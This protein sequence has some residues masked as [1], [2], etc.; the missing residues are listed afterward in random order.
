MATYI[1][2]TVQ[3]Y[4]SD[5]KYGWNT[6]GTFFTTGGTVH[7]PSENN[8]WLALEFGDAFFQ[9]G[10]VVF[11]DASHII[12]FNRQFGLDNNLIER[13]EPF[14]EEEP[15]EFQERIRPTA[16]YVY[17]VDNNNNR[18]GE[19]IIFPANNIYGLDRRGSN[20]SSGGDTHWVES[21]ITDSNTRVIRE[22]FNAMFNNNAPSEQRLRFQVATSRGGAALTV[23]PQ[24]D[25]PPPSQPGI[26]STQVLKRFALRRPITKA[27]IG[28]ATTPYWQHSSPPTINSFTSAPATV[29]LDTRA[30][31]NIT[32]NFS[33][34]NSTQNRIHNKATGANVPLTGNN[35]AVI[36]QPAQSTTYVLV[37]TNRTGSVSQEVTVNVT[38][39]PQVNNLRRTGFRQSIH[40]LNTGTYRF[41]ATIIGLPQPV[42]TYRFSTGENG[43]ITTRHL[44]QGAR[45]DTW[46][47]DWTQYFGTSVARSLTVTATNSSGS[48][49]GTIQNITA[50]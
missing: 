27:Y 22:T 19:P 50:G 18:Q 3:R 12:R 26:L 16:L 14:P 35:Q 44:T 49:T 36:A 41:G 11:F 21:V 13:Y 34:S 31:G 9:N 32:L 30:S 47:L 33:V 1:D 17:R 4:D 10:R 6:D 37:C 48:A 5:G 45:P 20:V 23:S 8:Q 29:D 40:G 15:G 42:L 43:T 25:P 2:V 28:R 24:A 7:F 46:T 39:N 38:R